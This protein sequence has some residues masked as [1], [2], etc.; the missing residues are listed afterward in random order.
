MEP[1]GPLAYP[2][3]AFCPAPQNATPDMSIRNK[4]SDPRIHPMLAGTPH[5]SGEGPL[6][7]SLTAAGA[8][9]RGTGTTQ[10]VGIHI[11]SAVSAEQ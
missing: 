1:Q 10:I 4:W 11:K 7:N 5:K 8:R 9:G 2:H 3:L 6:R